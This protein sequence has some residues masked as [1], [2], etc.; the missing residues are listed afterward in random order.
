VAALVRRLAEERQLG[1]F[2]R[3]TDAA[4]GFHDGLQEH[5]PRFARIGIG[6]PRFVEQVDQR[7]DDEAAA[8][9]FARPTCC[10]IKRTVNNSPRPIR[11]NNWKPGA[12]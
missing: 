11:Y 8:K 1:R 4:Q 9:P 3:R 10:N 6:G 12:D 7:E 2:G 5:A